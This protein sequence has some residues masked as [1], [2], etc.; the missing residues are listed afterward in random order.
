MTPTTTAY[1]PIGLI[2]LR[3]RDCVTANDLLNSVESLDEGP[4]YP[5]DRLR[6]SLNAIEK[7]LVGVLVLLLNRNDRLR[8]PFRDTSL[9]ESCFKATVRG[10]SNVLATTIYN[11]TL[12]AAKRSPV[13][14]TWD[15]SQR[16]L[17][18][19]QRALLELIGMLSP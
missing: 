1:I 19:Y 14:G 3:L 10:C 8:H 12:V 13:A 2:E 5:T 9:E 4:S 17:E 11:L 16:L 6:D 18:D 15:D 7:S